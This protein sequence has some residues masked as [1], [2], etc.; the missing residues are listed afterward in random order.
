[1]HDIDTALLRAF[2]AVVDTGN[3]SRAARRLNRTQSALSMQIKRLEDAVETVLFERSVR[4][5]SIT[6]AGIVRRVC[7]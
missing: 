4:P 1:M 5:P 6:P 2:V 7:A 3:F